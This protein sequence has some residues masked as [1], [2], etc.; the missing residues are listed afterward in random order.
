MGRSVYIYM[1]SIPNGTKSTVKYINLIREMMGYA[2]V[3]M[4]R[5]TSMKRDTSANDT[6]VWLVDSVFVSSVPTSSQTR[7]DHKILHL[8]AHTPEWKRRQTV[9]DKVRA[10]RRPLKRSS[11]FWTILVSSGRDTVCPASSLYENSHE[12]DTR[13]NLCTPRSRVGTS[14]KFI[15]NL[16]QEDQN[17]I[18]I[19]NM[20]QQTYAAVEWAA[21]THLVLP[22]SH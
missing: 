3:C 11:W 5:S 20:W 2:A 7:Y 12:S 6:G 9:E 21:Q 17:F 14:G 19:L 13:V 22:P 18:L 4:Y 8:C 15:R 1:A 16:K 10:R